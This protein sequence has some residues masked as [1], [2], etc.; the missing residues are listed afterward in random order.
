MFTVSE[1][2]MHGKW[3]RSLNILHLLL[4][5]KKLTNPFNVKII[6]DI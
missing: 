4:V 3:G 1:F 2:Q 6:F 5:I